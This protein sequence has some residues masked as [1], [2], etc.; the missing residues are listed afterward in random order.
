MRDELEGL[1]NVRQTL[2]EG[3]IRPGCPHRTENALLTLEEDRHLQAE[4]G[5]AAL[6]QVLAAH[7]ET[8]L[9]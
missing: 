5:S 8:M 1:L 3:C 4:G 6:R 2:L 9:V 7:D